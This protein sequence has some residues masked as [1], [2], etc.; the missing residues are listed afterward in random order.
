M[1]LLRSLSPGWTFNEFHTFAKPWIVGRK[2]VKLVIITKFAITSRFK[3]VKLTQKFT[4]LI[5]VLLSFCQNSYSQD[6]VNFQSIRLHVIKQQPRLGK[7]VVLQLD[8]FINNYTFSKETN[9]L[10]LVQSSKVGL[11]LTFQYLYLDG[12]IKWCFYSKALNP[13]RPR[14]KKIQYKFF[15]ENDKFYASENYNLED[16]VYSFFL[17][18]GY[19]LYESGKA[20]H[21]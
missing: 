19:E 8:S 11:G 1:H 15:L 18:K 7:R 21:K 3:F 4:T 16:S 9:E 10:Y 17:K 20:Y 2:F 12:K 14:G 13:S 6:S 5:I